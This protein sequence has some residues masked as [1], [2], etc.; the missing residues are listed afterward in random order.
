MRLGEGRVAVSTRAPFKIGGQK[1]AAGTHALVDLPVS[2]LSNHTP[3]TLPVH[4]VHGRE[5]GQTMFV[6]AAVHGDELNGV[7]RFAACC[8][9]CSRMPCAA[10]CCASRS[11]MLMALSGARAICRTGAI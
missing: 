2:K 1:V 8:G 11:S 3:I 5:A 7:N 9:S 10:R 6:S 4:V